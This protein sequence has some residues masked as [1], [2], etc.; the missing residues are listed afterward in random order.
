MGLRDSNK[1]TIIQAVALLVTIVTLIY[2]QDRDN[3][4]QEKMENRIALKLRIV[5]T[6][7]DSMNLKALC[8]AL[9]NANPAEPI[10]ELEVRKTL[11]EMLVEGTIRRDPD[12]NY[13]SQ[14]IAPVTLKERKWDRALYISEKWGAGEIHK[15]RAILRERKAKYNLG[16]TIPDSILQQISQDSEWDRSL[17]DIFEYFQDMQVAIESGMADEEYLERAFSYV[18]KYSFYKRY[19]PWLKDLESEDPLMYKAVTSLRNRW[20]TN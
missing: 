9:N 17:R 15:A 1:A 19:E 2:H 16:D 14:P 4:I 7:K 6:I 13:Q 18:F 3:D 11:Y 10:V 12:G 8:N 20:I 5:E